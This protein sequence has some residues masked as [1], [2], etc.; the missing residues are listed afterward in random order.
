[1]QEPTRPGFGEGRI[2]W[3]GKA[4]IAQWRLGGSKPPNQWSYSWFGAKRWVVQIHSPRPSLRLLESFP[5]S[6]ELSFH[7]YPSSDFHP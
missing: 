5:K 3:Q 1:M 6:Y 2:C 7:R 4:V